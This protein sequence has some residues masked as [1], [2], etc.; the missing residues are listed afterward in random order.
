[1]AL[2]KRERMKG[3]PDGLVSWLKALGHFSLNAVDTSP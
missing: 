2:V 1:M 3:D